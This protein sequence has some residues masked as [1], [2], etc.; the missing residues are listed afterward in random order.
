MGNF[1]NMNNQERI[2]ALNDLL[3]KLYI[4][5][6]T[7]EELEEMIDDAID[8]LVERKREFEKEIEELNPEKDERLEKE[9]RDEKTWELK[10]KYLSVEFQSYIKI[11]VSKLFDTARKVCYEI[12]NVE[13]RDVVTF[14]NDELE[15]KTVYP[16]KLDFYAV[17]LGFEG[18]LDAKKYDF[19]LKRKKKVD[20]LKNAITGPLLPNVKGGIEVFQNDYEEKYQEVLGEVVGLKNLLE[21]QL[22]FGFD[23]DNLD[24]LISKYQN[25][26]HLEHYQN[27]KKAVAKRFNRIASA[28]KLTGTISMDIRAYFDYSKSQWYHRTIVTNALVLACL[29]G[30]DPEKL[31]Y[32]VD[33]AV[34]KNEIYNARRATVGIAIFLLFCKEEDQLKTALLLLNPLKKDLEFRCGVYKAIEILKTDI[35]GCKTTSQQ[36][37]VLEKLN[38]SESYQLFEVPNEKASF[39]ITSGIDFL[40]EGEIKTL[41]DFL[42]RPLTINHF[43]IYQILLNIQNTKD[44]DGVKKMILALK[45]YLDRTKKMFKKKEEWFFMEVYEDVTKEIISRL[46]CHPILKEYRKTLLENMRKTDHNRVLEYLMLDF[47]LDYSLKIIPMENRYIRV[48]KGKKLFKQLLSIQNTEEPSQES[49]RLSE[50][51]HFAYKLASIKKDEHSSIRILKKAIQ[52][53]PT[54]IK[55]NFWLATL[56]IT[57]DGRFSE[58]KNYF[59]KV[60]DLFDYSSDFFDVFDGSFEDMKARGL[61]PE[62]FKKMKTELLDYNNSNTNS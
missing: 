42:T 1:V 60:L 58:A 43:N 48:S 39:I 41:F 19:D 50:S 61:S 10:K 6:K 21:K 27:E 22:L 28:K 11:K 5:E 49:T 17:C 30:Y 14:K 24:H 3:R 47:P 15:F 34:N 9:K 33:V 25:D 26:F 13:E 56:L 40:D 54:S 44:T 46:T 55:A 57:Q 62:S 18:Y 31:R 51:L 35:K 38:I 32:L 52:T 36:T 45:T 12:T 59:E 7:S 8:F 29:R 16:R 53:D 4:D 37:E 2:E 23:I 20:E